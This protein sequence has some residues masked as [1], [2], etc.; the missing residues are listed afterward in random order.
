LSKYGDTKFIFPQKLC[1]LPEGKCLRAV[2][3]E[4]CCDGM[5][6]AGVDW[7]AAGR[8]DWTSWRQVSFGS[9]PL[10]THLSAVFACIAAACVLDISFVDQY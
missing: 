5:S 6:V 4:L 8:S 7:T 1:N 9:G 10:A 3:I 2:F